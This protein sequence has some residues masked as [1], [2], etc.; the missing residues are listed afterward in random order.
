MAAF[1]GYV[2]AAVLVVT[3]DLDG[4]HVDARSSDLTH[5]VAVGESNAVSPGD[6]LRIIGFPASGGGEE[7]SITIDRG[8]VSGFLDDDRLHTGR[9]WI[10]TDATVS[11]GNSGGLAVDN[12][13]RLVGIPSRH[14]AASRGA[15]AL[16][17]I[18]SIDLAKPLIAA[19]V[20]GRSYRSPYYVAVRTAEKWRLKGW[21]SDKPSRTCAY[22]TFDSDHP[23]TSASA[24]WDVSGMTKGEAISYRLYQ[25]V[26]R[27]PVTTY[28][29]RWRGIPSDSCYWFNT[30][31]PQVGTPTTYTLSVTADGRVV[32]EEQL[33]VQ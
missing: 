9:A 29:Q 2:D 14:F 12:R 7:G 4:H 28:Q 6:G 11:P 15:N 13:G 8:I 27:Q 20:A 16:G 22:R 33:A 24:V 18:R 3:S 1:D 19:A 32:S 26:D 30:T 25:G 31:L 17:G 21:A 5:V 10:K 23:S